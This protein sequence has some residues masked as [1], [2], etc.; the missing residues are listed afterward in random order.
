[1]H[2][3]LAIDLQ[4]HKIGCTISGI[5]SWFQ[6]TVDNIHAVISRSV[7]EAVHSSFCQQQPLVKDLFHDCG[8]LKLI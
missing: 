6:A 5:V 3:A 4:Q 2:F 7:Y 8:E 1:V